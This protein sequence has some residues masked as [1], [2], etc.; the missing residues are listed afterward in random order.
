MFLVLLLGMVV[1]TVFVC[2]LYVG[3]AFMQEHNSLDFK[4][5]FQILSEGRGSILRGGEKGR[6]GSL[7][8]VQ[9]LE[10]KLDNWLHRHTPEPIG[11]PA[12]GGAGARK[13]EEEEEG[14]DEAPRP[15]REAAEGPRHHLRSRQAELQKKEK[16]SRG[17][18]AYVEQQ[19]QDAGRREK[20]SGREWS[21]P[22]EEGGELP[23]LSVGRDRYARLGS[24]LGSSWT[25]SRP[26]PP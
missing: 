20:G 9:A 12:L 26:P 18:T 3:S 17:K 16:A 11:H 13:E 19:V 24:Q 4:P 21:L 10:S 8:P 14:K 1:G 2:G 5:T 23:A 15:G 22:S 7:N 6:F 25:A